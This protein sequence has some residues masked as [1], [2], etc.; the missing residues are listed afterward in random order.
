MGYLNRLKEKTRGIKSNIIAIYLAMKDKRT[1]LIAKIMIVL[2]ISYAVSPIDLI[3][4]FIPVLGYL[5]DLIILPIMITISIKLIPKD[6]FD[7]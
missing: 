3:P 7:D 4:D 6:V 2:T 5:D 1:P